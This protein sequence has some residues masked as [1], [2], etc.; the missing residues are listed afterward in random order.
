MSF[1]RQSILL[2]IPW[3][4]TWN[5]SRQPSETP[6]LLFHSHTTRRAC[7]PSRGRPTIKML[8]APSMFMV[9]T[10][11]L[12]DCRVPIRPPASM[13]SERTSSGSQTTLSLNPATCLSLRV[14]GFLLG[15]PRH[16]MTRYRT[17]SPYE[18]EPRTHY[19]CSVPPSIRRSSRTCTTRTTSARESHSRA[20]T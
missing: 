8:E 17:L 16:S 2:I 19:L 13:L 6:V 18:R 10:A 9:L 4:Y 7:D 14:V 15:D 12:E 11:I 20:F 3:Y 1:R 5:S